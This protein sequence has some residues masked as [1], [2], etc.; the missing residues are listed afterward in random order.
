MN[1]GARTD[2]GS[3]T[4]SQEKFTLAMATRVASRTAPLTPLRWRPL[5]ARRWIAVE[6]RIRDLGL[7]MPVIPAAPK[8]SYSTFKR[9]G[10]VI[11]LSG[12]LPIPAEG[13]MMTGRLGQDVSL[14]QGQEAARLCALQ[15][16]ASMKAAVGDLDNVKSIIKVNGF[17]NSTS[18]FTS[19]HLVINGC[20]NLLADV[21]GLEVGQHAR[22]AVGVNVL[23]LNVPVEVEAIIT[24]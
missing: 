22:S 6:A 3:A 20:S 16:I 15:M 2:T 4:Y 8:G 1:N 18:D 24:V 5:V 12:H 9:M 23:P 17:V 21:F 19:H 7:S 14:E 10:N 13:A 11:Y